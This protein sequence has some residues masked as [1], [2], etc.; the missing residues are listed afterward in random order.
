MKSTPEFNKF[1]KR[2]KKIP[3]RTVQKLWK[4]DKKEGSYDIL[5]FH[6]F[7]EHFLTSPYEYS[8][9]WVDDVIPSQFSIHF[10]YRNAKN[11]IF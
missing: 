7:S 1:W 2:K 10:I 11:L 5:K 6:I 8:N 4:S 9:E 3:Y